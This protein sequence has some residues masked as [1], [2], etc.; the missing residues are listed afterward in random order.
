MWEQ[1]PTKFYVR[2][3]VGW[4]DNCCN[5]RLHKL[6]RNGTSEPVTCAIDSMTM[7]APMPE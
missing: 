3:A 4:K 5:Q 7:S 2:S 1:F 6:H